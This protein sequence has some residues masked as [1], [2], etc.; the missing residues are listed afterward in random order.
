MGVNLLRVKTKKSMRLQL[1]LCFDGEAFFIFLGDD[2]ATTMVW[3]CH[4]IRTDDG[5]DNYLRAGGKRGQSY[6]CAESS[7]HRK[8]GVSQLPQQQRPI[9][10]IAQR[11]DALPLHRR[12]RVQCLGARQTGTTL[13]RLSR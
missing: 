4:R 11:R 6:R 10:E 13:H 7:S 3:S 9:D 5:A 8:S 2:Y 1:P 12:R